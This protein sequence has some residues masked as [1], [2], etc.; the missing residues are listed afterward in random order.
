VFHAVDDSF[1]EKVLVVKRKSAKIKSSRKKTVVP[2][3]GLY[4]LEVCLVGGPVADEFLEKNPVVSRTIE[5]RA[6]QTLGPV[7]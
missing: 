3:N 2:D 6:D 1:G 4:T 7:N 5:I